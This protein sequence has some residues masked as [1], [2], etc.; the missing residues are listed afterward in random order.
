MCVATRY[1]CCE[2]VVALEVA[3]HV[4]FDVTLRRICGDNPE[5]IFIKFGDGEVSLEFTFDIEPLGVRDRADVAV[6]VVG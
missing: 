3:T 1:V 2:G 6:D 4:S 5:S